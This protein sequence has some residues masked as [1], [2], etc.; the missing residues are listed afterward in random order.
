[1]VKFAL[2]PDCRGSIV[3]F[4]AFDFAHKN[5]VVT[6]RVSV[7]GP[8]FHGYRGVLK[9]WQAVFTKYKLIVSELVATFGGKF[10]GQFFMF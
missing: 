7:F 2:M 5:N 6:A 8:T 10:E 9:Q 3:D 4:Y 1:M